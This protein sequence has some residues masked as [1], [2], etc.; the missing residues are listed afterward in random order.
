MAARVRSDARPV[1]GHDLAS[2]DGR[3]DY[4][5]VDDALRGHPVPLN[6][7]EL[8]EV[9][10]VLHAMFLKYHDKITPVG[11]AGDPRSPFVIVRG[12]LVEAY[13]PGFEVDYLKYREKMNLRVR[14][15]RRKAAA[16]P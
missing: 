11:H 2:E 4:V 12:L 6:K 10:R 3:I 8:D 1:L 16:R 13:G 9:C 15:A 14:R 5:A 7:Y